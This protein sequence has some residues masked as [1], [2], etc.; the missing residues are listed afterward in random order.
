MYDKEKCEHGVPFIKLNNI[1]SK[2]SEDEIFESI[3]DRSIRQGE[4]RVK[5]SNPGKVY[6]YIQRLEI[7]K[8]S[9]NCSKFWF[10]GDNDNFIIDLSS[11]LNCLIG[12]RGSGKSSII[13]SIIF[14]H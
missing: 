13:E 8:E 6:E 7:I 5:Y 1:N 4:T 9:S 12:G 2:I 3:R 10:D 11:N 14:V